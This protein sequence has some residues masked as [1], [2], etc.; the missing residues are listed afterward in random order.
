M[1]RQRLSVGECIDFSVRG[2]RLRLVLAD[3]QPDRERKEKPIGCTGK[4]ATGHATSPW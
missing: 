2:E 4:L 3:E 1:Q